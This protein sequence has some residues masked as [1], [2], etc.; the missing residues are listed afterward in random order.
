MEPADAIGHSRSSRSVPGTVRGGVAGGVGKLWLC[1][2]LLSLVAGFGTRDRAEAAGVCRTSGPSSYEVTICITTPRQGA[3]LTG[4]EGVVATVRVDGDD[5]GVRRVVFSLDARYLL[6]DF[7]APYRFVF[8]TAKFVDRSRT[9]EAVALMQDEFTSEA[10]QVDVT[11]DNGNVR[12]PKNPRAFVASNGTRGKPF[13]L[14]AAGDGADG[15]VNAAALTDL[16]GRW[17]PNLFLYLGDVY[18]SGSISEFTNWYRRSFG[19]FRK[20]TDPAIGNH[21]YENDLAPGYFDYWDNVRHHYSVNAGRWHLISLDST[22]QFDQL[23]PGSSQYR[24][25]ARDLSRD[26]KACTLAFF[27]HPFLSVGPEG[28]RPEMSPLWELLAAGGVDVVLTGHD[29]SYQR[30]KP[31]NA[32]AQPAAHGITQFVVG[33]GGHGIQAFVRSDA[34]L[35]HGA[36]SSPR[37]YGALRMELRRKGSTYSFR[38]TAHRTLDAGRIGCQQGT[39]PGL[40][41]GF[42]RGDL[43]RWTTA[44]RLDVQ[45]RYVHSGSWAARAASTGR[46]SFALEDLKPATGSILY[47][48]WFKPMRVRSS[49]FLVKMRRHAGAPLLGIGIGPTRRLTLRDFVTGQRAT[50]RARLRL[51]RWH[52]LRVRLDASAGSVATS[53]DGSRLRALSGHWSFHGGTIGRIQLGDNRRGR[54]FDVAFDDVFVRAMLGG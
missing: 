48:M 29:H 4:N 33:T 10:T 27:H 22:S 34:R 6:T 16:I 45:R 14:A 3:T 35:A 51:H 1:V 46:P 21:E 12:R 28:D 39:R 50:S 54:S 24:W 9:L 47:R 8:P 17:S 30:W 25:L 15:G 20:I 31:L 19:R 32:H 37:A 43:R 42:E 2:A 26:E 41:D 49:T 18:E 7:R 13:V 52:A 11:L 44:R 38:N 23:A 40:A 53:L 5:P 36:D